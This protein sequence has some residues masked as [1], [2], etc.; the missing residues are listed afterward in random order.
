MVRLVTTLHL[1]ILDSPYD[2]LAVDYFAKYNVL[3]VQVWCRNC[4]NEELRAVG[5]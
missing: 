4:G 1:E 5:S 3:L 2:A